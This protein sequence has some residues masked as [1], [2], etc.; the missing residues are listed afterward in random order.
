MEFKYN[1]LQWRATAGSV[2]TIIVIF[3]F[4]KLH[5]KAKNRAQAYSRAWS[6]SQSN[7]FY[8]YKLYFNNRPYQRMEGYETE[9]GP[10]RPY[11]ATA[12]LSLSLKRII[13]SKDNFRNVLKFKFHSQELNSTNTTVG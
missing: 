3:K 2:I 12:E 1:D 8:T 9:L 5:L 4:L 7:D 11:Y 10:S 13:F 6:I